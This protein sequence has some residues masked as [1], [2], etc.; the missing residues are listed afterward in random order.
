MDKLR[1][2]GLWIWHNKELF[3]AIVLFVILLVQIAMIFLRTPE[4]ETLAVHAPP[5]SQIPQV[6]P[7]GPAPPPKAVIGTNVQRFPIE[8]LIASNPFV[9]P[10]NPLVPGS[11]TGMAFTSTLQ[12]SAGSNAGA[13][14][15]SLGLVLNSIQK[16]SDGSYRAD[17]GT[18]STG[19]KWLAEGD[20]FNNGKFRLDK[21]D[22][23]NNSVT[24]WSADQKKSFVV[25][26]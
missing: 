21:I 18:R 15:Q 26:K 4:G 6:W 8:G 7:N 3:M 23:Q 13:T 16:W 24:I 20:T 14:A 11:S 1:K 19:T 2:T 9:A 5:G 12:S 17:V 22:A 25:K 10:L